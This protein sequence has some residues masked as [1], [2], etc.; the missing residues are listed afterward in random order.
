M[1]TLPALFCLYVSVNKRMKKKEVFKRYLIFM[2]A[3]FVSALGVSIITQSNL[4]TSPI[5]SIPYVLSLNSQPSMGTYIF[6]LNMFLIAGQMLMLG[7]EGILQRKID[8][9]MQIPVSVLFGFFIDLTMMMISGM[10]PGMYGLKVVSLVIGCA[11]LAIGICFEVIADV[12]MVSGEYFV[13]I[14]SRRF[15]KEFGFVKITFDI[16]LVVIAAVLSLLLAG[17]IEGLREGTV[18]AAILT[19]PFVRLIN[20]CLAFVEHW[21]KADGYQEKISAIDVRQV[22]TPVVITI[23]A[24]MEVAVI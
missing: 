4:G 2:V 22:N 17:H 19:G 9:L 14:A 16:S 24:N 3:L 10:V 12:T 23:H 6:M 13:Q 11:V 18:I 15:K 5:S 7:K 20:P 1:V 21:E 8:L